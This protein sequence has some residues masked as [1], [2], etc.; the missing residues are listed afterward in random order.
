MKTKPDINPGFKRWLLYTHSF[1]P[2]LN[3]VTVVTM[4]SGLQA[5]IVPLYLG[6]WTDRGDKSQFRVPPTSMHFDH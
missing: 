4:L 5:T 1:L 6:G 2:I 3:I